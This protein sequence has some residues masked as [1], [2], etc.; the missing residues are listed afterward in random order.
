MGGT[1]LTATGERRRLHGAQEQGALEMLYTVN[2]LTA[3]AK[4]KKKKTLLDHRILLQLWWVL[5]GGGGTIKGDLRHG[6]GH[7]LDVPGPPRLRTVG[8]GDC[9]FAF[10]Y[11]N[12]VYRLQLL[13]VIWLWWVG[14]SGTLPICVCVFWLVGKCF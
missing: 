14:G 13:Y 4:K 10:I 7:R 5:H 2:T 3:A 12:S 1:Q 6:G 11:L 9:Y 8:G